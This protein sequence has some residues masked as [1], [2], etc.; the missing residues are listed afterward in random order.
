M[1]AVSR[2]GAADNQGASPISG[3]DKDAI[4]ANLVPIMIN[5][6]K[7]QTGLL[8]AQIGEGLA[9]V[10]SYD[11]PDQWSSLVDVSWLWLC[12]GKVNETGLGMQSDGGGLCC[13]QWCLVHRSLDLQKASLSQ[14]SPD[15]A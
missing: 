15:S 6:S 2:G 5:L 13:Q 3:Q 1:F 7:P 10:A 4:K 14:R 8:Q 11:F 9:T 12:V